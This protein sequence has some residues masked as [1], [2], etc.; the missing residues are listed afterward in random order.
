MANNDILMTLQIVPFVLGVMSTT[1]QVV[2]TAWPMWAFSSPDYSAPLLGP[3]WNWR[4]IWADCMQLYDGQYNCEEQH[5]MLT[6]EGKF[7]VLTY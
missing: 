4:G 2:V 3:A 5:S 1:T 7:I 6:E